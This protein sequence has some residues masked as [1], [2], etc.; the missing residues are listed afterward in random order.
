MNTALKVPGQYRK[1]LDE[2]RLFDDDFFRKASKD[3]RV[4]EAVLKAVIGDDVHIHEHHTQY[5]MNYSP[6]KSVIPDA[7]AITDKGYA[8]IEVERHKHRLIPKRARY[9]SS[10][11]DVDSSL[12]G[13]E[14][15]DLKPIWVIFLCEKDPF[16]KGLPY[17]CERDYIEELGCP[18]NDERA[19]IYING[20]YRGND[21]IGILVH[22]LNQTRADD[23]YNPK[24]KE[25]MR[26]YKESKEGVKEMCEVFERI[27]RRNKLD[28]I[29]ESNVNA[30]RNVMKNFNLN[31]I[32]AMQGLEIPLEEYDMYKEL[33]LK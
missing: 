10:L 6:R 20:E 11:L 24:L 26:Y 12:Q 25:V 23:M 19:V 29:H 22:D 16:R 14:Y 1:D 8:S 3:R 21:P 27:A 30:I 33:V 2:L 7:H 9:S 28:G 17:Y 13:N 32:Q 5:D 18:C 31:I 4:I 15:K